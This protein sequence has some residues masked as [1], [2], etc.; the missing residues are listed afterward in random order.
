M[1]RAHDLFTVLP[2]SPECD[3][4]VKG[5]TPGCRVA[6]VQPG[7]P[8]NGTRLPHEKEMEQEIGLVSLF[9]FFGVSE[10]SPLYTHKHIDTHRPTH[11]LPRPRLI[12][13]RPGTFRMHASV[14]LC[15]YEY[16]GLESWPG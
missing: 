3:S 14:C 7:P 13:E 5:V 6:G 1:S 15:L 16:G 11:T 4:E 8:W 9:P 2:P 10:Q 12:V